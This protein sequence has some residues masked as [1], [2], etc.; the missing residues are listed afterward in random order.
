MQQIITIEQSSSELRNERIC[1]TQPSKT[2][3]GILPASCQPFGNSKHGARC[4]DNADHC[5]SSWCSGKLV[6]KKVPVGY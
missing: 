2:G 6:P 4:V 3:M 1:L 5:V